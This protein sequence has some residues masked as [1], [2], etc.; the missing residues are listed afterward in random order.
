MTNRE[1][2][3]VMANLWS[4]VSGQCPESA[5]LS[6][7]AL[8]GE[9]GQL[10]ANH[11][12][13][14]AAT[15][16]IATALFA[17]VALDEARG[18]A[19]PTVS[20]HQRH[21][22][23]AMH[24]GSAFRWNG[25]PLGFDFAPLSR[26]WEV[27][28]GWVRTH[29]NYPWHRRALLR[30][31]DVATESE[32]DVR[33]AM[34]RW[35]AEKLEAAVFEA[36]GIVTAM[37]S[38]EQWSAHPQGTSVASEPLVDRANAGVAT[39]RSWPSRTL[40][41]EGLRVLDLTRVIAGPVCTRYLAALGA[42]VFRIDP[43]QWPD[44]P[45][46]LP[47][48]TLLGKYSSSMDFTTVDGRATLDRL[49][50]EADMVVLG[51]RPGSLDRFGLTPE[52]LSQR[53]PGLVIIMLSAWGYHGPWAS[54]RG[55]DSV[56]QSA[57]GIGWIE[58]GSTGQPGSLPCQLL[59][60]GTGYLAAAAALD[61]IREQRTQGG[62]PIR[63]LSLARTAHWLLHLPQDSH[64]ATAENPNGSEDWVV[65]LQD[66]HGTQQALLPVGRWNGQQL[67]WP[68]PAAHYASDRPEW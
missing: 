13:E 23:A 10:A 61:G 15:A 49:L 38:P 4:A 41:A 21:V 3:N 6:A 24:S 22:A 64:P 17:G 62:T 47:A 56:V 59:D 58:G 12:V 29:A 9:R 42:S 50:G 53:F 51:Y 30:V 28:D 57:T 2:Y 14:A 52:S 44:L 34:Q 54:R 63:R 65:E 55:F 37:R 45:L 67:Q 1:L 48:D 68:K 36:G 11:P 25:R 26:F 20:V 35:S 60:H 66:V 43:P 16:T 33:K 46:G 27:A 39:P 31:L 19:L 5:P 7:L 8:S 32:V 40:P 18:K